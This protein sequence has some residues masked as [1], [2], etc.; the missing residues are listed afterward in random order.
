MDTIDDISSKLDELSNYS[1][2]GP[3]IVA[4][5]KQIL[6]SIEKELAKA[7]KNGLDDNNE[8]VQK[9]KDQYW[10]YSKD[11]KDYQ[12]GVNNDAKDAI[13]QLIRFRMKMISKEL[14]DEK[15]NL[16]ERL[17][18]LKE[19]YDNQKE[20]LRDNADEEDYLKEQAKKRKEITD[21]E[22]QLAQLSLDTS[23]KAQKKRL[24]LEEKLSEAREDLYIFERDHSIEVLEDQ[25]DHEYELAE[26]DTDSRIEVIDGMLED[27]KYLYQRALEDIRNNNRELYEEMIAYNEHYID[28][29]GDAIVDMWGE[30]YEALYEYYALY[31]EAFEG[32]QLNN[33]TNWTPTTASTGTLKINGRKY[34]GG[35]SNAKGGL[36]QVEE[37]GP[38]HVF[39]TANGNKYK[40]F[41]G[42]E[43]VLNAKATQFLYDFANSGGSIL[44]DA[45]RRS[46]EA[47]GT[48]SR[49]AASIG[50][51]AMGD[52][53]VQG[54]AS[55]KTVSE[56]R[57]A[58]RESV[59][60]LLKEFKKLNK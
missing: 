18:N 53:I 34:A 46:A 22:I 11:L 50:S 58:Q 33:F 40:L 56:I 15:D 30:A 27:Q 44:K 17:S 43:K 51:V 36:S 42:G 41:R 7:Y 45:L 20:L 23:A 32:I 39:V 52:I 21:L 16:K 60:Y 35:T 19:F 12:D 48:A 14:N 25:Y 38:E 3:K 2:A 13:E 8:Y 54:D 28:G 47:M 24:E 4:Y 29:T 59:D 31:K 37:L 1:G 9:L 26:K 57:R 6:S 10:Q 55:G 49:A 5:Y